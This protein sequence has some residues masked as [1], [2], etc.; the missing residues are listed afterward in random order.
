MHVGD[1]GRRPRKVGQDGT[2]FGSHE[3]LVQAPRGLWFRGIDGAQGNKQFV[4]PFRLGQA[5]EF[6]EQI[7]DCF[8][9]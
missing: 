9:L 2:T 5:E 4:C 6:I 1:A 8:L 7:E 3:A